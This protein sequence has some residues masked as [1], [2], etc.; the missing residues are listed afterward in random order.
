MKLNG[1]PNRN[2]E[3]LK[4]TLGVWLKSAQIRLNFFLPE[5]PISSLYRLVGFIL[6]KPSHFCFSH[7][8]QS[9]EHDQISLLEALFTRLL[10]GTPL[11][12][13]IGAQEFFGREFFITPKVLIPRPETEL[14]VSLAI[15]WLLRHP[16]KRVGLDVGSGSGCIAISI[17]IHTP[18]AVFIAT[19]KSYE[20]LSVAFKNVQKYELQKRIDLIQMDLTAGLARKFDLVCANLPYIPKERLPKLKVQKHEPVMALDGGRDGLELI[21]NLLKHVGNII[22]PK[23]VIFLEIDYLQS[24]AIK[25]LVQNYLPSSSIRIENDLA[26]KPRVA[27]IN[28]KG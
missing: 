4:N 5:E 25:Q 23:G 9:L 11:P 21:K 3:H 10:D 18:Q 28:I 12:Y 6:D 8:E 22:S 7:P 24:S 2:P 20:A 15:D 13:L 27:V 1:S 17:C 14:L 26:G 19:D 16:G